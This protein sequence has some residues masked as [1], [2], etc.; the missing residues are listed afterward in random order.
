MYR[1]LVYF[2]Y[3]NLRSDLADRLTLI[4]RDPPS[5][6]IALSYSNKYGG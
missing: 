2:F 6:G 3:L 5:S 4:S 1:Q